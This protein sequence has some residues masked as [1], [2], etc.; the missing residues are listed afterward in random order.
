MLNHWLF[1]SDC[2]VA[3]LQNCE[4]ELIIKFAFSS[5]GKEDV[6]EEL[7]ISLLFKG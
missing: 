3:A 6:A 4:L 5:K 7:T 1:L 2:V